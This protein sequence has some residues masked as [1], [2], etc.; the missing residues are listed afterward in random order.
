M[1]KKLVVFD[2][3]GTLYKTEIVS[4]P[5]LKEAFEKFD[6]KLSKDV[7]LNQFGEPTEQI[8]RNLVPEE[9]YH[10]NGQIEQAIVEKEREWIPKKATLYTGVREMLETLERED[11]ELA[12]CSNGRD[13]Y[14]QDVLKTTSIEDHFFSVKGYLEEKTKAERIEDLVKDHSPDKTFMVGDRYHDIEA[15]EQA[16]V[17]SIGA[18]YGYGGEE[19]KRAD[20]VVK[21]PEEITSLVLD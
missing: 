16:G 4:V 18:K 7:I 19:A 5:A 17:T 11:V 6:I 12:I 15:A 13:D 21:E 20:H 10:L 1:D 9:K 8:I 3:D 2:L 14:I